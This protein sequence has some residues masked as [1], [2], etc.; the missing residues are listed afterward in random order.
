[1]KLKIYVVFI[2]RYFR[3]TGMIVDSYTTNIDAFYNKD[4]AIE[5]VEYLR[6]NITDCDV[7]FDELDIENEFDESKYD[8]Y[9]YQ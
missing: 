2:T 4:S 9:N 5:L 6:Q 3:D 7:D 8:L 1:M